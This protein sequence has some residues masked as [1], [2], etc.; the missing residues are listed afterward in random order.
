M[1]LGVVLRLA[2][3]S[4]H[5]ILLQ[6][7]GLGQS[8]GQDH[9]CIQPGNLSYMGLTRVLAPYYGHALYTGYSIKLLLFGAGIMTVRYVLYKNLRH[10]VKKAHMCRG[11]PGM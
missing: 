3:K 11:G 7:I 6:L 1:H 2:G 8:E 4:V 5:L 10:G 9:H